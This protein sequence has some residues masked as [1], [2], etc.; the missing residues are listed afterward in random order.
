MHFCNETRA[1][2]IANLKPTNECV[3]WDGSVSEQSRPQVYY[4][5]RPQSSH[6]VSYQIHVGPIPRNHY[7]VR[8]CNNILCL[9]PKHLE[10]QKAGRPKMR[11]TVKVASKPKPEVTPSAPVIDTIVHDNETNEWHAFYWENQKMVKYGVFDEYDRAAY[12]L[13]DYLK[14]SA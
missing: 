8:T 4:R 1:Q 12:A 7:V 11:E 6:R 10:L 3:L 9:N 14:E 5:G 13:S 2:K